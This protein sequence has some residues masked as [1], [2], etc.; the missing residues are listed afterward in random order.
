MGM[1][2][3]NI[4]SLSSP[5]AAVAPPS[6][7]SS[8]SSADDASKKIRKPYTITK[9]RES[10]TEPE[11]DK[12]LEALQL[13]DRDWKKIEAFI[14]SKTVIQIR[15]HAQK[16]FLK[17]Q[18]SGTHEHL[19]PPRPK[20]KAAHPYPQKAAKSAPVLPNA[21]TSFQSAPA[22]TDPELAQ[23]DPSKVAKTSVETGDDVASGGELVNVNCC[24]SDDTAPKTRPTID[25][26]ERRSHALP[27]RVLPDFAQVYGF[28][29]SV[30]DPN[31][32]GHEQRLKKMDPIDVET[33]LLLMR[34]LSI[35]L[36]SPDF[37]DHRKL[38]S[39]YEVDLGKE[40]LDDAVDAFLDC[41]PEQIIPEKNRKAISKYLFQEGVCFAKKDYNLAKHP[42]ID[43]PNLQV[44]KLM[45]SF[46]SKE[47]VK[48]TFAWMHYYW[49]LTNDGI[50]FLRTYLNLPSDIVPA[51]LKKSAKPLG[52]PTGGPPGD[53]PRGP[54]RFEGDRPRFGDRDGY[55]GGPRGPPGEFGGEKGGAPADYQPAFNRG[56][57][58]GRPSFGRGGG[59]FGGGAPPSSSFS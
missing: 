45:Q 14:G 10:W 33:V 13:F 18:K 32:I 3:P 40:N 21:A 17:V 20:R 31:T 23:A 59:G 4:A 53:R 56:G 28:I 26:H 35:N 37:E 11:H 27:S 47:Y 30:F 16:Y 34:N 39:T 5:A 49:Y 52:R 2:L 8:S 54:P 42:E 55:R 22:L 24:S 51:T 19:P 6:T 58:G 12:F 41:H 57:A 7:N 15:S 29:G 43:V 50:E 1:A 44:I 48:E 25:I 36:T 9:S 46:K 38:L